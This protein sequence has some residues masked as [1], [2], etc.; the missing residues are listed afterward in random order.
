[1]A[2][3]ATKKKPIKQPDLFE[4]PAP[5]ARGAAKAARSA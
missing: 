5:A 2:K 3:S 1:M 4:A